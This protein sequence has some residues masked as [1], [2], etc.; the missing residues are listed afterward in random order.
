MH[1]IPDHLIHTKLY[2]PRVPARLVKRR[3]L[4]ERLVRGRNRS[5]TLISAPAGYG[6]S[7]LA[8]EWLTASGESVAIAKL[9]K[10]RL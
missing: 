3:Q 4:I 9:Q 2:P 1:K 7:T 5:V 8:H 6:K 10:K